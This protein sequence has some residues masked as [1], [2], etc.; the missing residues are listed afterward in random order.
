MCMGN[1]VISS[2][3]LLHSF[4]GKPR[5]K[6]PKVQVYKLARRSERMAGEEMVLKNLKLFL[7][8]QVIREENKKLKDKVVNLQQE[9][10]VL[11]SD[12]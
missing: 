5:P 2:I 1:K 7:E 11:M 6:R 3:G 12:E 4:V 9:K 8:N 10:L